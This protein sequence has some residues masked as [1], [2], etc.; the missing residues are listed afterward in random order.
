MG[1]LLPKR[2]R[3]T[4]GDFRTLTFRLLSATKETL[5][6]R[7]KPSKPDAGASLSKCSADARHDAAADRYAFTFGE[8]QRSRT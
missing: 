8:Q 2:Q 5:A 4:W 1:H 3:L 6:Q 7:F